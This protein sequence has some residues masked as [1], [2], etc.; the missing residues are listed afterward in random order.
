[1]NWLS[2]TH[3]EVI[4]QMTNEMFAK[5]LIDNI[6]FTCDVCVMGM[7]KES[8]ASDNDCYACVTDWLS[9]EVEND[10]CTASPGG[11]PN[12]N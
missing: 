9:Q 1:M 10:V 3:R 8:C 5:F 12:G 2:M 4:N 6:N 7:Y 11:V